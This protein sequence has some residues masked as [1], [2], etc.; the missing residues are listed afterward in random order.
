MPISRHFEIVYM[1]LNRKSITAGEL[2][3]H[4]EVSTRTI[5]RD[6]DVL[7]AAGIPVYASKGRG[8]GISLLPGYSFDA[9]LLSGKEQEDVLMALQML[10]ATEYPGVEAV[11]GKFARL[12]Q[13]ERRNWLEVDFSP[14]GSESSRRGVFQKMREAIVNQQIIHF[15]YYN[16]AGHTSQRRVE[17]VQLIFKTKAWYLAGYCLSSE[18]SRMFKISR[19]RDMEVTEEHFE[20]RMRVQAI[21]EAERF[22]G[23]EFVEMTL[24]ISSTGAFRVYDEFPDSMVTTNTDGS[25]TVKGEF[26][27]GMWLDHYLLSFGSL[28]EEVHPA[29]LRERLLANMESIKSR[30]DSMN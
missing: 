6:I 10:E 11:L 30:L 8:G 23:Q 18:A 28:L 25:F 14:W 1:L 7:S 4:F 26:P 5:Y 3:Q 2:A 20:P 9:S 12:F 19:M 15:Q 24:R 29:S 16:S 21:E 22:A 17:P 13:K 27:I